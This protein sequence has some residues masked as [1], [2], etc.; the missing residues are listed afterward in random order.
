MKIFLKK[1][2]FF[3]FIPTIIWGI[4]E[5]FLPITF[6]THRHFEAISFQT[7][8]PTHTYMYP[9]ISSSMNAVGDMCHHTENEI[10]KQEVWQTD[11]LGFRNDKFIEEA[12][13]LFIGDSFIEGSSLSQ[14]EIVSNKVNKKLRGKKVYNMAPSSLSEFDYYLKSGTI[15]KPKI[16]IFSIVERN[17]PTLFMPYIQKKNNTIKNTIIEVLSFSN[18]NVYIDKMLKQYSI[19]WIQ[20]RINGSKGNGIQSKI[21]PRMFFLNGINQEYNNTNLAAT[22]DILLS[23][24]KYCDALGIEFLFLPMPN[25]E[26]VYFDLVPFEKQSNYLFLLDSMLKKSNINTINSLKIYN[27]YRKSNSNLLYHFDDTHWNSNGVELITK[28]IVDKINTTAQ[29]SSN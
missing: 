10:I 16:I 24:K 12:D 14:E 29:S 9:N 1:L 28:A 27:D 2:I 23:Y 11:K 26:T 20:A 22:R 25:K 4:I 18:M 15:K 6:F 17:V 7:R 21:N 13:I 3:I 8:V 19:K 5:A